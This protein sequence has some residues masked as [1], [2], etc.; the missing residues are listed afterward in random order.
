MC[1]L[2]RLSHLNRL[3]AIS[4]KELRRV[5][6]AV[7]SAAQRILHLPESSSVSWMHMPVST[8]GAGVPCLANE[9]EVERVVG[10]LKLLNSQDVMARQLARAQLSGFIKERNGG[11]PYTTDLTTYLTGQ[12]GNL[13]ATHFAQHYS[14]WIRIRQATAQVPGTRMAGVREWRLCGLRHPGQ[15]YS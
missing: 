15:L 1:L 2:S 14:F 3:D 7:L 9:C 6:R 12:N 8:G 11:E 13:P 4:K 10:G 5:D